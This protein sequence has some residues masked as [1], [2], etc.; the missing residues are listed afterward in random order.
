MYAPPII[1]NGT[2]YVGGWDQNL[3]AYRLNG[4]GGTPTPTPT[5]PPGDGNLVQNGSFEANTAGWVS[6][7]GAL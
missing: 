6:W 7:Q 2:L 5:P 3:Y 1:V 4:T